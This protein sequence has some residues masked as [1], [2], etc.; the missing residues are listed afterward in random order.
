MMRYAC[1]NMHG[2]KSTSILQ[3][4]RVYNRKFESIQRTRLM[5]S[6]IGSREGWAK[7]YMYMCWSHIATPVLN[8]S[9]IAW[10]ARVMWAF[11][12]TMHACM[13]S[14]RIYIRI[15]RH[16][17]CVVQQLYIFIRTY[18][19]V[20]SRYYVYTHACIR[21]LEQRATPNNEG[22]T[23]IA[24]RY[25]TDS[26]RIERRTRRPCPKLSQAARPTRKRHPEPW[27][28]RY[29]N[30]FRYLQYT[31]RCLNA[32]SARVLLLASSAILLRD[33]MKVCTLCTTHIYMDVSCFPGL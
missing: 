4:G 5:Y 23:G 6:Q 16:H 32:C 10:Y 33:C 8:E 1:R 13:V 19:P 15:C 12:V 17:F 22:V 24:D 3:I 11:G 27:A 29:I 2:Q 25:T 21:N 14:G 26:T 7:G 28:C 9:D 18:K 31:L 30:A 20:P